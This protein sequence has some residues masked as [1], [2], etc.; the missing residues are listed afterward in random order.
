MKFIKLIGHI[1]TGYQKNLAS[2]ISVPERTRYNRRCRQLTMV[3]K[4]Y[5]GDKFKKHYQT[6]GLD[7]LVMLHKAEKP[8]S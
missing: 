7:C 8:N 5:F 6:I 2:G 3:L 4:I 1:T